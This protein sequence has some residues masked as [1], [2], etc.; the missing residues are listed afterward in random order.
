MFIKGFEGNK[1]YGLDLVE[2]T[3]LDGDNFYCFYLLLRRVN[4]LMIV[5]YL[6]GV[7][8]VFFQLKKSLRIRMGPDYTGVSHVRTL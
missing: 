1:E 5:P 2:A 4:F 8:Q 3:K 6:T 7:A